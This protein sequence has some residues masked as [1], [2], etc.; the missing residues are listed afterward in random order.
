MRV[1][2]FPFSLC[3]VVLCRVYFIL[4]GSKATLG[5]GEDTI[6]DSWR[7]CL[8]RGPELGRGFWRDSGEA[9]ALLALPWP[10]LLLLLLSFVDQNQTESDRDRQ[11]LTGIGR[12]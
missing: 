9:R 11:E 3:S 7:A 4:V 2:T 5:V 12:D 8:G 10:P 1:R 6:L